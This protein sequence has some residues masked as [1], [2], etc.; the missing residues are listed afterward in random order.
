MQ[1]KT[2]IQDDKTTD[3]LTPPGE[4]MAEAQDAAAPQKPKD[5]AKVHV[6]RTKKGADTITG[7]T[8]IDSKKPD[9][10]SHYSADETKDEFEM[11]AE[12]AAA[13][14]ATGAFEVLPSSK[15]TAETE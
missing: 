10:Y 1:N 15:S 7:F 5:T 2:V 12:Q 3:E 14:V 4:A 9:G 8:Y 13:A 11:T 6:H